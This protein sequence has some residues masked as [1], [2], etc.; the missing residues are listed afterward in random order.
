MKLSNTTFDT[1]PSKNIKKK[2]SF[3]HFIHVE[4]AVF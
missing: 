2:S 1:V 4:Y 3:I